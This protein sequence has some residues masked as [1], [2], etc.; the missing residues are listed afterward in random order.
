MFVYEYKVNP[1]SNQKLAIDEA[2]RT[3]QFVR[4]KVGGEVNS[5]H[6]PSK[7]QSV[8]YHKARTRYALK[9]LKVSRQREE[10]CK[11]IALR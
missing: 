3:H 9:H 11:R 1:K 4:N 8:N 5:P 10:F 7:P 6:S 2:I